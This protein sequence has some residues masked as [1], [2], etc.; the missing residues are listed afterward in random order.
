M[1]GLIAALRFLDRM[2]LGAVVVAACAAL[3]VAAVLAF[4]QVILRFGFAAP[5]SW[6]DALA[7]LLIVWMVHLGV[8]V[9]M[10]SGA[11]VSVDFLSR[12]L[13]PR[14]RLLL[15]VAIAAAMLAFLGNLIWYGMEMAGRA[16]VQSHPALGISMAWGYA[17]VPVGAA[18]STVTLLARL[19]ERAAGGTPD[20]AE[21]AA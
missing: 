20:D 10:R 13:G 19:M 6:A 14:P 17:A 5:V 21:R 16:Q 9:T 11:L 3:G 1:Q 18:L 8:A 2:I 15:E 7:Q 4:A 12:L